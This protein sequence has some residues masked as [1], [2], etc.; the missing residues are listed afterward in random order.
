[1]PRSAFLSDASSCGI[2][3]ELEPCRPGSTTHCNSSQSTATAVGD[4][5]GGCTLLAASPS[6]TVSLSAMHPSPLSFITVL[7]H[8]MRSPGS[9]SPPNWAAASSSAAANGEWSPLGAAVRAISSAARSAARPSSLSCCCGARSDR[10]LGCEGVKWP[11]SCFVTKHS[12]TNEKKRLR[13]N[14][15]DCLVRRILLLSLTLPHLLCRTFVCVATFPQVGP[16]PR[17]QDQSQGSHG[18]QQ[19]IVVQVHRR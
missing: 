8:S 19:G 2:K 18:V 5:A 4:T 15:N 3:A 12:Y 6:A 9:C 7:S 1:L 10:C 14:R 13:R 16:E 17:I 11:G